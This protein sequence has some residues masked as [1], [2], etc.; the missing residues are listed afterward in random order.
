MNKKTR[1]TNKFIRKLRRLLKNK[2][3]QFSPD[4][5]P[6]KNDIVIVYN[7]S[8][9]AS[10]S[11]KHSVKNSLPWLP[12]VHVHFLGPKYLNQ[13]K[14]A[15]TFKQNIGMAQRAEESFKANAK[16]RKKI[17]TLV[18]DPI[19]RE[20]SDIFQ[21]IRE[22]FPSKEPHDITAR[23]VID[24]LEQ[25]DFTYISNWF[26]DEFKPY[27]DF[28][29]FQHDFDK[30]CGYQIYKSRNFDLLCL[31]VESLSQT[32]PQAIAEFLG[33]KGNQLYNENE[34]AYKE[35]G[36]V[37]REVRN[38]FKLPQKR[39]QEIYNSKF[40]HKFYTATEIDR[41]LQKWKEPTI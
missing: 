39:L 8:K 21:S 40:M 23:D 12:V 11:I 30:D 19:A 3:R 14:K 37:Y 22:H 34:S 35:L 32:Y 20:L 13:Q 5:E 18:R 26:D 29:I 7:A 17:I 9:V 15:G 38:G 36:T 16:K 1:L 28:D 2:L 31:K 6:T 24:R 10:S 4:Y 25:N 41:L 27:L 33:I